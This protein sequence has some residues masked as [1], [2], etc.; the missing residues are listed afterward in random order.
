MNRIIWCSKYPKTQAQSR[1][2]ALLLLLISIASGVAGIYAKRSS[3]LIQGITNAEHTFAEYEIRKYPHQ[4]PPHGELST[5]VPLDSARTLLKTL[6][7]TW[8]QATKV[9][10]LLHA[11]RLWGPNAQFSERDFIKPF[12]DRS[13]FSGHDMEG[14]FTDSRFFRTVFPLDPPLLNRQVDG[15]VARTG[16]SIM[17]G[18]HIGALVHT[19]NLLRAFSELGYSSET[20]LISVDET[21]NSTFAAGDPGEFVQATIRDMIIGSMAYFHHTQE[22]EW[23]AEALCRYIAPQSF[24]I[25]RFRKKRTFDE[26]ASSFITRATESGSCAGLHAIYALVIMYRVNQDCEYLSRSMRYQIEKY[27]RKRSL[28]LDSDVDSMEFSFHHLD[29]KWGALQKDPSEDRSTWID[30]NQLT[31]ISHHLEWIA[32]SPEHLRPKL[33]TVR[34][35]LEVML[36]G[37]KPWPI[38]VRSTEYAPLTHAGKAV[39]ALLGMEA[40]EIVKLSTD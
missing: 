31:Y 40:L 4:T 11:F 36:H 38:L 14:I 20:K 17:A 8:V 35:A 32:Y 6:I 16:Y 18:G 39:S 12:E 30:A 22:T 27:L 34:R 5:V 1:R 25:N 23:T 24:W 26:I 29:Q 28:D 33:E 10:N 3:K 13:V 37:L 15:V 2:S 7:P 19:D 21:N 9:D